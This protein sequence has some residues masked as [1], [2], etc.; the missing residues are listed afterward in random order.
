M[1]AAICAGRCKCGEPCRQYTGHAERAACD[2]AAGLHVSPSA[3][4]CLC[5]E[6]LRKHY[7]VSLR[8]FNPS[9][10]ALVYE[11]MQSLKH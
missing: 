6:C 11:F 2:K 9:S 7:T 5:P 8:Q 10:K 4:V 3:T 1:N